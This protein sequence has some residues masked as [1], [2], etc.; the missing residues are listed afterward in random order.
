M[1]PK[2][3]PDV[4]VETLHGHAFR[5]TFLAEWDALDAVA[6][7]CPCPRSIALTGGTP[8]GFQVTTA[9]IDGHLVAV[10][11]LTC[12]PTGSDRVLVR[13]GG[14]AQVYDGPTL[15]P[16]A[17]VATVVHALWRALQSQAD[18]DRIHLGAVPTGSP[19]LTFGP[20]CA[21]AES[22]GS[23]TRLR[24]PRADRTEPSAD[25]VSITR[26]TATDARAA[27]LRTALDWLEPGHR[28]SVSAEQL[29][30]QASAAGPVEVLSLHV[31]GVQAAVV[32]GWRDGEMFTLARTLTD[33]ELDGCGVEGLVWLE[34]AAWC[35]EQGV[36][37]VDLAGPVPSD[38]PW[39]GA[40]APTGVWT[41]TLATARRAPS[42]RTT[43]AAR[44]R[45]L[46]QPAPVPVHAPG[47][48]TLLS[49][50]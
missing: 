42:F 1:A 29:L 46:T 9:R 45:T 34:T 30:S 19:V 49:V 47:R 7:S 44:L 21:V 32:V 24:T 31:D 20:I 25:G 26:H 50:A 41:A 5:E 40:V 11:P 16:D 3:P 28:T 23:T 8:G 18:V 4:T 12:A 10:W 2:A 15:H 39:L 38:A 35:A 13:P 27:V 6:T 37:A 22:I 14:E 48:R 36:Q 33:P 17:P 43:A